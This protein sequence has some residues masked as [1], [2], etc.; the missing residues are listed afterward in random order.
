M[1]RSIGGTVRYDILA[2]MNRPTD[3]AAIAEEVRR[4]RRSGLT[5]QDVSQALRISPAVIRE[6]LARSVEVANGW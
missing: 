4:L 3:P 1:N 6:I 5:A 2:A